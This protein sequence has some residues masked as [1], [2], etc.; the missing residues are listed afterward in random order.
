[1]HRILHFRDYVVMQTQQTVQDDSPYVYA[2]HLLSMTY[3]NIF[4]RGNGHLALT[5][6]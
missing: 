5:L 6:H 3:E 4:D 2:F 1:M